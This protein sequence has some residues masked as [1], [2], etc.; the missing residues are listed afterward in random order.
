VQ[1]AV[2]FRI[3]NTIVYAIKLFFASENIAQ[4]NASIMCRY[5]VKATGILDNKL[6]EGYIHIYKHR[7]EKS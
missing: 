5:I 4:L 3:A 6:S 7:E 1:C 2:N